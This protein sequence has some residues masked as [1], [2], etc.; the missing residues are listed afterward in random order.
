MSVV[1]GTAGVGK[2]SLALH[3]AHRIREH[4]PDGQLYINLRGYDPGTP[5]TPAQALDYFLRALDVQA[6]AIPADLD[7]RAALYRSLLAER[8]ILVLLDNA[9]TTGQVRPLLPGTA[10]C[11]VVVT[12]RS[13]LSGLVFRDG[14]H[15]LS[16]D[17]LTEPEAVALLRTV[18][19]GYRAEADAEQLIALARLCAR[20]PL[21]LRIAAEHAARRPKMPLDELIS[22]LRDESGLWDALSADDDEEADAIRTVF[23]WSY[24]ALPGDAARMFRLLG[25]HPGPEFSAAAAGA[26]AGTSIGQV[27][28]LLD[29]LVG[30]HLLEQSAPDRYQFHDLLRAYATDQAHQEETTETRQLALRRTLTWYLHSVDAAQALISPLEPR[31]ALDPPEQDVTPLSFTNVGEATRWYEAE[32]ANL[33]AATHA[34][35][36]VGQYQTA[37]QLPVVLRSIYM[38]HNPFDD[39]LTTARIG[40]DAARRL[41]D[42]AAEAELLESLAIACV[43]SQRLEQGFEYYHSALATR[44]ALDDSFGA[45]LALNGIGLLHLRQR[46]LINA[47]SDFEQSRAIFSNLDIPYW[48]AVLLSNLAKANFEL[49]NLSEASDFV[50]HALP[51]L[52]DHDDRGIEGNALHMLSMIQRELGR[53]DEA[54]TYIHQALTIARE[55]GNRLWEGYWLLEFGRVQRALEQPVEALV[56]YQRAAV[57]QR[58]LGDRSREAQALDGTGET[59]RELGRL[60]EAVNFHRF[61]VMTHRELGDRWQLA[62]SLD[63]LATVLRQLGNAE[64]SRQ[65]WQEALSILTDFND[66]K[67]TH[68]NLR[69][70]ELLDAD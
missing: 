42:R 4:F 20:L 69:I 57:L 21:A 25:L 33:V 46:A 39:W 51:I 1:T 59:Y 62:V 10:G 8:R 36:D 26:L 43:Q 16:L 55:R 23:A 70:G 41:N 15:R 30:A 60:D 22:D 58:Q 29:I 24:R 66:P 17:V 37:W 47:I 7:A 18:T 12:S 52:H 34:A 38:R 61:A 5:V 19:A 9:A 54:L 50:N 65:H 53:Q 40:L 63:N 68:M 49:G 64:E 44:R 31:V 35:A 48:D 56:S 11:L 67:A 28:R 13:R 6:S 32:R 3:W 2:T 14:A 45:A 27:R